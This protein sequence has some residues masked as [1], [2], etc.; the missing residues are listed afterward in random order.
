MIN[1]LLAELA[2]NHNKEGTYFKV[3][4]WVQALKVRFRF[5]FKTVISSIQQILTNIWMQIES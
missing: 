3:L 2:C 4:G 1:S 5:K